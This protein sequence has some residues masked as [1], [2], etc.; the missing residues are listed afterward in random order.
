MDTI[1]P[2]AL[3]HLLPPEWL[4]ALTAWAPTVVLVVAVTSALAHA[5][6]ALAPRLEAWA[7][8]TESTADD[9]AVARLLVAARYVATASSW[10]AAILPRLT[11]GRPARPALVDRKIDER[12][13]PKDRPPSD[14]G[15]VRASEG[16]RYV[17]PLD[18]EV[19]RPPPSRPPEGFVA[20]LL[21]ALAGSAVLGSGCSSG[22]QL[23]VVTVPINVQCQSYT[24]DAPGPDARAE[25]TVGTT[26]AEGAERY[27]RR[28]VGAVAIVDS[29]CTMHVSPTASPTTTGVEAENSGDI[30]GSAHVSGA[31]VP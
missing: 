26:S 15:A 6:L 5:V 28:G 13:R 12:P 23:P 30:E 7:L 17:E 27:A 19:R 31:G 10:L 9:V 1:D 4:A 20:L 24:I 3:L 25:A 14:D 11:V 16:I 18:G 22:P 8:A 2:T 29:D 21:V